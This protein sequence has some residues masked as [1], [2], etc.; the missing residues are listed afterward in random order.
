MDLTNEQIDAFISLGYDL[1][2]HDQSGTYPGGLDRDEWE[3][4]QKEG[5]LQR[6]LTTKSSQP[7]DCPKGGNH[8]WGID[9]AHSNEF[10]KKCFISSGS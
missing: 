6:H 7:D 10:C 1:H 8:K 2:I 4:T 3:K 5:I 9:G